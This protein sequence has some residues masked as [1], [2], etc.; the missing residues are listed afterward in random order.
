MRHWR[1][2]HHCG[3]NSHITQWANLIGNTDFAPMAFFNLMPG[4]G[5]RRVARSA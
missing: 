2:F 1:N 4:S 5:L 3:E